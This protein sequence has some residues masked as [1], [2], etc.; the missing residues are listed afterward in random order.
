MTARRLRI[1]NATFMFPPDLWRDISPLAIDLI[2][3]LLKVE[4]NF[5]VNLGCASDISDFG[6]SGS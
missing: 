1:Q 2:Q 3:K 4:V 5:G 6:R